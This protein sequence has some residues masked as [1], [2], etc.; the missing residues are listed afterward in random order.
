MQ[1]TINDFFPTAEENSH[2]FYSALT[3]VPIESQSLPSTSE[4]HH[5]FPSSSL[6][7][8]PILNAHYYG[9][10]LN[11]AHPW[12]ISPFNPPIPLSP[13]PYASPNLSTPFSPPLLPPPNPSAWFNPHLPSSSIPYTSFYPPRPQNSSALFGTPLP[14]PPSTNLATLSDPSWLNDPTPSLPA[15]SIEHPISVPH[16]IPA[17]VIPIK[18]SPTRQKS[19][20]ATPSTPNQRKKLLRN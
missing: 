6:P 11:P 15:F 17:A 2:F 18:K 8:D 13:I 9:L 14:L 10:D 1:S 3:N 12:S 16:K 5:L 19:G 7:V 20:S 4:G